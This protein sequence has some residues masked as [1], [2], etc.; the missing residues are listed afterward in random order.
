MEGEQYAGVAPAIARAMKRMITEIGQQL[1]RKSPITQIKPIQVVNSDIMGKIGYPG[2]D[3]ISDG[4]HRTQTA[5]MMGYK[6]PVEWQDY[7]PEEALRARNSA[8]SSGGIE[9]PN[10]RDNWLEFPL[11]DH[12]NMQDVAKNIERYNKASI[13]MAD[14]TADF[15]KSTE[16]P[17]AMKMLTNN[18]K[19][20]H[21]RDYVDAYQLINAYNSPFTH[22]ASEVIRGGGTQRDL[23]SMLRASHDPLA[24]YLA[25]EI[26]AGYIDRKHMPRIEDM[27][28]GKL[29]SEMQDMDAGRAAFGRMLNR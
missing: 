2:E 18:Y 16:F 17:E 5:R 27:A 19:D 22:A 12:N 29:P 28:K 6:T 14:R 7:T 11:F 1:D 9:I 13:D 10:A 4:F 24:R 15:S 8:V 25:K 23:E 3:L 26:D 21:D 20:L